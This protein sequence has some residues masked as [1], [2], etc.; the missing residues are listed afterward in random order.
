ML[1]K[2]MTCIQYTLLLLSAWECV[3]HGEFITIII[4]IIFTQCFDMHDVLITC[5]FMYNCHTTFLR[6]V[7]CERHYRNNFS[8]LET[9]PPSCYPIRNTLC[10]HTSCMLCSP[11]RRCRHISEDS[12]SPSPNTTV[13]LCPQDVYLSVP[14]PSSGRSQGTPFCRH[15]P[16]TATCSVYSAELILGGL[17]ITR[18]RVFAAGLTPARKGKLAVRFFTTL[19]CPSVFLGRGASTAHAVCTST[20]LC[21]GLSDNP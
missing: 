11:I 21:S 12:I 19:F 17:G 14:T 10:D 1:L 15:P 8:S 4:T 9:P 3:D 20:F 18:K 16:C 13:F 2:Y 5:S 6:A 7:Y